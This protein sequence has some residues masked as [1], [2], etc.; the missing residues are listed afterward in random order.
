M[1]YN[2]ID[3]PL[4]D[5]STDVYDVHELD[6]WTSTPAMDVAPPFR[7]ANDSTEQFAE[8][9]ILGSVSRATSCL[10]QQSLMQ[11]PVSM[12]LSGRTTLPPHSIQLFLHIAT[13][14]LTTGQAQQMVFAN[15]LSLLVSLIPVD[16]HEW[17]TMPTTLAG[18]QSHVLNPTNKNSLVSILPVP[19]VYMLPDQLHA[20]C[21]LTEIASFVLLLPRT[22]GTAPIPL[23]LR[24][25]CQSQQMQDFIALSQ[26]IQVTKCL[27]SLGIMFWMDGWDPS[28]SSKNNRSPVHTASATIICIDNITGLPFNTRTFPIAC[29]PGK[30]DHNPIFEALLRSYDTLGSGRSTIW[31]HHH[32]CWTTVQIHAITFL[33]DQPERRGSNCLLGGNSKQHALFGVSCNFA[34]L[35]KNFSACPTCLRLATAYLEAGCFNSPMQLSCTSCYSFTLANLLHKGRYKNLPSCELSTHTPGYGLCLSPGVLTFELLVDAWQYTMECFVEDKNWSKEDVKAY[36]TTLCINAATTDHFIRLC[37][38]YLLAEKIESSPE[39]FE[40]DM[41]AYVTKDQLIHQHLYRLPTPPAAWRIGT[42]HQRVETIMNFA[43]NTQKAVMRLVLHWAA[44]LDNGTTLIKHLQPMIQSV[45]EL[46]LPFVPCRMFKN[47][48]FGG[49]V[50]ENYRALTMLA[51]WLFRCLLANAFVPKPIVLP[52]TNKPRSKWTS[53]ENTAWLKVRGIVVPAKMPAVVRRSIVEGYFQDTSGPPDVLPITTATVND[54]RYLILLLFRV[55]AALFS[56]DLKGDEAGN[57]FEAL[58]VQFLSCVDKVG[59]ACHPD[60]KE[61]I[62]LTKVWTVGPTSLSSTFY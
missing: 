22:L 29:G 55:F 53:R 14:L 48:K 1:A 17:P 31:S 24:Q 13:M 3:Y 7:F 45:Q 57:R 12:Y 6:Q 19:T 37:C 40:E 30:A 44:D 58:V 11:G 2:N 60:K 46:R 61:P 18:F 52:P 16:N 42:M 32:G 51:P 47:A 27:V 9:C 39:E 23:R 20:Y 28:A 59:R 49:F 8:W 10:V 15:I 43:M 33:M 36:F 38:N 34:N 5:T 50:A 35:E 62:W 21:C 41:I 56:T 26:P 25:L 54:I 4:E